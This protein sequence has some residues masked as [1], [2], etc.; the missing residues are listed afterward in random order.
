[1]LF[2]VCLINEFISSLHA[3]RSLQQPAGSTS[4]SWTTILVYFVY[5]QQFFFFWI[6]TDLGFRLQLDEQYQHVLTLIKISNAF[7]PY[8]YCSLFCD[9]CI[10]VNS[11][12]NYLIFLFYRTSCCICITWALLQ[13]MQKH[14]HDYMSY[15]STS[16]IKM[17]MHISVVLLKHSYKQTMDDY[18]L[19]PHPHVYVPSCIH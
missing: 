2:G 5:A 12:L 4:C 6:V 8:I 18:R 13:E 11:K 9:L 14:E 1:M 15:L 7:K 3:Y 10:K 19:T 16:Y 17:L